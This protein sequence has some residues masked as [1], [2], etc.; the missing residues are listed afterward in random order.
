[1][2]GGVLEGACPGHNFTV[3]SIP[4]TSRSRRLQLCTV[5]VDSLV[6][7]AVFAGRPKRRGWLVPQ[8]LRQLGDVA[9]I[10]RASS[11]VISRVAARRPGSSAKLYISDRQGNQVQLT[12]RDG[13]PLPGEGNR[14]AHA[15][16]E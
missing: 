3:A 10:R 16:T 9:A 5:V 11:R 8:Q 12:D 15:R 4:P 7:V 13:V 1:M 6:C 14:R 2:A